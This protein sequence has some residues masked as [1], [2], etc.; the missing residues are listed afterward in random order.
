[1]KKLFLL[2]IALITCSSIY[3][4]TITG[5]L[6]DQN[7]NGLSGLQMKLM[8]KYNHVYNTVSVSDGSFIFNNV[9][10]VKEEKLPTG[11]SVSEN[12]PNPFNPKTRLFITLPNYGRV[13]VSIYNVLGQKV[14]E[15]INRY[16]N[17]GI[18][19]FDIELNG[20]SNG[21]YFANISLDDKYTVIKKLML[22]YGSQHLNPAAANLNNSFQSKNLAKTNSSVIIDSLVVTGTSIK[23][24]IF[25]T[26]PPYT[27]TNLNLGKLN[28]NTQITGIPCPGMPTVNYA[29]QIYN[30]IQIGWQCWLKENLNVGTIIPGNQNQ[31]NNGIIEKYCYNDS[32]S[33]CDKYGGLY[34]WAEAVQ[35]QNGASNSA[36]A[37]PSLPWNVQGI[38]PNGWY[39][40]TK[41]DFNTLNSALNNN[42]NSLKAEG[43]GVNNGSDVG[44]G[45]NTSGFS[46]LLTGI[47]NSTFND[48][49]SYTYFWSSSENNIS[50]VSDMF[51]SP[52]NS[53]ITLNTPA[54]I[55]GLSV[56]CF[57]Y[58]AN[59]GVAPIVPTLSSPGDGAAAQVTFP[60]LE[61]LASSGAKSYTLQVSTSSSFTSFVF[62][63]SGITNINQQVSGLSNSTQYYW[64]VNATNFYGTSSWSSP[65]WSFTTSISSAVTSCAGI[66]SVTYAGQVYH[67]VQIGSQCWL[68]E[69]L[70]IGTQI[71]WNNAGSNNGIIEKFCYQDV[72]NNCDIYGGLYEWNEAMMYNKTS[73]SQGICPGGWHIPTVTEFQSL[74]AAVGDS[75]NNLKAVGQGTQAGAGNDSYGFSALLSGAHFAQRGSSPGFGNLLN[76]G[77]FWSSSSYDA[78]NTYLLSLTDINNSINFGHSY[79]YM[80]SESNSVIGISVRCTKD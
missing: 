60:I 65:T 63:K 74:S 55:F 35:Y 54:K 59:I 37:S 73:G 47:H 33:N 64:R 15:D 79:L 30:T 36:S 57:Q 40:P 25:I 10:D 34:Q 16:F 51:L 31:L 67:T 69:N 62:N 45:T 80:D 23:K 12:F 4:Q 52:N 76:S 7:G 53:F 20:L 17:A 71:I 8:I 38:C 28:V 72:A 41:D 5:K 18:G 56:R 49:G 58:S 24:N 61:W 21:I 77:Y 70:N 42:G 19:Y 66:P 75:S 46:A 32:T 22:L 1:M 29:G 6:V 14:L 48:L 9:S 27:G 26:M 3:A 68:K 2:I 44:S 11:Y 39:L 50:T 78:S 43:Q 13:K